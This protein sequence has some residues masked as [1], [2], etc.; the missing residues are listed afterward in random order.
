MGQQQ[1]LLI[2]L[3]IVVVGI[4]VVTGINLFRTSYDEE[5]LDMMV[6]RFNELS[7]QANQY[8]MKP[9]A[10]GGGGGSYLGFTVAENNALDYTFS[11]STR[12]YSTYA[13]IYLI[14]KSSSSTEGSS[15]GGKYYTYG[16]IDE[17]GIRSLYLWDPKE[18]AW[19]QIVDRQ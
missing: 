6:L 11:G 1:L 19:N 17:Y 4:A 5:I 18:G 16:I 3:G 12:G 15:F 14:S 7:V 9:K 8:R 2:V 13:M 10:T